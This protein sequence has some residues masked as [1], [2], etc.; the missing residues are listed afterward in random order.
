[1]AQ[2]CKPFIHL[3]V[4]GRIINILCNGEAPFLDADQD[5]VGVGRPLD[6]RDHVWEGELLLRAQCLCF[7][8]LAIKYSMTGDRG[9]PTYEEVKCFGNCD[10]PAIGGVGNDSVRVINAV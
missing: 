4:P 9:Q 7:E 5:Q 10:E 6:L 3:A 2:S 8:H 1:M